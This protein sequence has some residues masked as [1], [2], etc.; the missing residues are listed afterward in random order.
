MI[1][2]KLLLPRVSIYFQNYYSLA[3]RNE[4]TELCF[5]FSNWNNHICLMACLIFRLHLFSFICLSQSCKSHTNPLIS[6]NILKR[7]NR[8]HTGDQPYPCTA[9]GEGFRTKAELNQHNRATHGGLNPNSA[10]TTI[11]VS[12]SQ[13]QMVSIGFARFFHLHFKHLQNRS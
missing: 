4:E 12:G 9:C 3:K 10:N 5:F 7:L 2:F 6:S 8:L 1:A 11:V 13:Q